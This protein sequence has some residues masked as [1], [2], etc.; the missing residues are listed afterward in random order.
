MNKSTR[1][2]WSWVQF[3]FAADQN[4]NWFSHSSISAPWRCHLRRRRITRSP[5]WK[6]SW[7]SSP[8]WLRL[9]RRKRARSSR[10]DDFNEALVNMVTYFE[11]TYLGRPRTDGPRRKPRFP[12]PTWSINVSVLEETE[13][14][15]N[16]SESWNSVSKL[17]IVSSPPCGSCLSIWRPRTPAWRPK[18]W[19]LLLEPDN[20]GGSAKRKLL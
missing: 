16:C 19:H 13:F 4:N 12:I 7:T 2:S 11:L 8:L 15:T 6:A 5:R 3:F 20:T 14:S 9:S 18:W 1:H 10:V 17:T